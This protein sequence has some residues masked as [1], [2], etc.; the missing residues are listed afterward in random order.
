MTREDIL[1]YFR[2]DSVNGQLIWI[3][4]WYNPVLPKILGKIAG[5]ESKGYN[6]VRINGKNYKVHRIIWFLETGEWP[7]LIDHI[8]GNGLNNHIDNIRSVNHTINNRNRQ[9]HREGRLLGTTFNKRKGMWEGQRI[10]NGVR[11]YFGQHKTEIEAH[12]AYLIGTGVANV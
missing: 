3:N 8:D 5:C 4:H 11:E 9:S 6:I 2:Y 7:K 12:Q 1:Y 10:I